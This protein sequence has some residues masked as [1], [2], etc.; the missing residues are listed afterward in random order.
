M[1]SNSPK[2]LGAALDL[3]VGRCLGQRVVLIPQVMKNAF[4]LKECLTVSIT[5]NLSENPS[6]LSPGAGRVDSVFGWVLNQVVH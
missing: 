6:P 5:K 2:K 3:F 4:V 1:S